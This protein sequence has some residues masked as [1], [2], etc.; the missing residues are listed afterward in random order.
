MPG[1]PKATGGCLC[2]AVRFR[3][4]AAPLLVS[5]CHCRTCQRSAGAP[6]VAWATYAADAFHPTTGLLAEHA[7]SPAVRRGFCALCGTSVTYRTVPD[8]GWLDVTVA[9]LDDPSGF[10][11]E[12]HGWTA[13][14]MPWLRLGDRLPRRPGA[15]APTSP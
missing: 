13:D 9:S 10:E 3:T 7:S 6:V 11:P 15:I 12:V 1:P 4:T 2:G 5:Y 14:A 8:P